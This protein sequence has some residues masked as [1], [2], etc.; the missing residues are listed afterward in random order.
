MILDD[1]IMQFILTRDKIEK[2]TI[3]QRIMKGIA[4][5]IVL[6]IF[7]C[8]LLN[9]DA[10]KVA[11]II[12][13]SVLV[14]I[15]AIDAYCVNQCVKGRYKLYLYE[16]EWQDGYK[17]LLENHGG[18]PKHDLKDEDIEAPDEKARLPILYYAIMLVLDV[19]V[20][21]VMIL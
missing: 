11:W 20:G 15:F 19:L 2:C 16:E 10:M 13:L 6:A 7:L 8:S 18:D 14:L 5:L 9:I 12:S 3:I 4:V 21:I 1:R 17:K